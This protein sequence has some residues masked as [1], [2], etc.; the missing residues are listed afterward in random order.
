MQE[1]SLARFKKGQKGILTRICESIHISPLYQRF[2]EMGFIEGS[3]LE[4]VFQAFPLRDPILI[5]LNNQTIMAL[6]QNEAA[7]LFCQPV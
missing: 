2:I 5:K 6:R 1:Q 3:E 4:V 7:A